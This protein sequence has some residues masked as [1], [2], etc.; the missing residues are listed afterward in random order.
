[1]IAAAQARQSLEQLGL[2]EAA[3]VLDGRLEAAPEKQ[4]PYAEFLA[5]SAEHR[6]GAPPRALSPHAHPA[7]AL[8]VSPRARPV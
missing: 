1:M 5:R 8:T 7:G 2:T 3:T 6:D 4:L